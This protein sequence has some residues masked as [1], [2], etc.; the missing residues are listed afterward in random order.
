MPAALAIS[1]VGVPCNPRV[2][3]PL[4]GDEDLLAALIG[5]RQ[6]AGGG[7]GEA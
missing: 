7:D 4:G 1:I 2:A 5:G 3:T 6:G